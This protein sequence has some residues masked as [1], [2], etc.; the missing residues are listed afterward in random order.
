MRYVVPEG[1][2][3]YLDSVGEP[4]EPTEQMVRGDNVRTVQQAVDPKEAETL[5]NCML[6]CTTFAF[7]I[8]P[9]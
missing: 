8:D 5:L 1:L 3:E 7:L 9:L 6:V 2:L 4:P